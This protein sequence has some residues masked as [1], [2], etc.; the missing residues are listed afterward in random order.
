M[1]VQVEGEGLALGDLD[2]LRDSKVLVEVDDDRAVAGLL[3]HALYTLEKLT[4][5]TPVRALLVFYDPDASYMVVR[6]RL[7]RHGY[8]I[9]AA[10]QHGKHEGG[11]QHNT[12]GDKSWR[13]KLH[14][15]LHYRFNV[16]QAY[17][18]ALAANRQHHIAA[19]NTQQQHAAAA[20]RRNTLN[21][22]FICMRGGY[23]GASWRFYKEALEARE[24][25][26][27][28]LSAHGSCST[29]GSAATPQPCLQTQRAS[30]LRPAHPQTP[31]HPSRLPRS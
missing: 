15:R 5:T 2:H 12:A 23:L 22:Y 31:Q 14:E 8:G 4:G 28:Q 29:Q 13:Y 21:V 20:P 16:E 1:A 17:G 3:A 25:Q 26:A 7:G 10:Q 24:L 27:R 11:K 19:C 18:A 9:C 30:Q 6:M